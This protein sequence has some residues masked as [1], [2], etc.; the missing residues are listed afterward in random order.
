MLTWRLWRGVGSLLELRKIPQTSHWTVHPLFPIWV[1]SPGSV[2]PQIPGLYYRQHKKQGL[3][4]ELLLSTWVFLQE[5]TAVSL[6]SALCPPSLGSPNQDQRSQGSESLVYL[7][8]IL[9]SWKSWILEAKLGKNQSLH[10]VPPTSWTTH[11]CQS[12]IVQSS[13]SF[14]SKLRFFQSGK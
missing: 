8:K 12:P 11:V 14:K 7:M 3:G 5:V 10:C 13:S 1:Q 2:H 9:K 4:P 6:A